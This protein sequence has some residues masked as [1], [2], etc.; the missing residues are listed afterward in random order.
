MNARGSVTACRTTSGDALTPSQ[1]A[2]W[3]LAEVITRMRR[4]LRSGVRSEFAWE[5]LPMAQVELLQRLAEEPGLRVKDLAVRHRLATNTVSNLV[6]QMVEAGLVERR[7]DP[8]DRRAV[9]LALTPSGRENLRGWLAANSRRLQT[10][11]DELSA[12]DRAA[13]LDIVPVLAR[14]VERL[15]DADRSSRSPQ[16]GSSDRD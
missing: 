8:G 14:L 12:S 11:L 3:P 10:A 4:V 2:G 13:I 16:S 1:T 15:E 6:Q 5:R 9:S 7:P